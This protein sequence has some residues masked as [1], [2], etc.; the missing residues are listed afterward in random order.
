MDQSQSWG[1]FESGVRTQCGPESGLSEPEAVRS[2]GEGR[3]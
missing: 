2:V 1:E 3:H